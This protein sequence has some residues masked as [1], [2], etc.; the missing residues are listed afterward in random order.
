[1]KRM[2]AYFKCCWK[3]P[4]DREDRGREERNNLMWRRDGG[5]HC[6]GTYSMAV[7]QGNEVLEDLSQVVSGHMATFV[8]IYDGHNGVSAA[9]YT[10]DHLYN[11]LL[12]N[13]VKLGV[14]ACFVVKVI[15]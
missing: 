2:A 5:R 6:Y 14:N 7:G 13:W 11:N 12:G 9:S 8:G 1:M 15:S 10:R 3:N 4:L